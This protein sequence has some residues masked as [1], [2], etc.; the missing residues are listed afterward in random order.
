MRDQAK[1]AAAWAAASDAAYA[2]RAAYAASDAAWDAARDA[3]WDAARAAARDAASKR[4]RRLIGLERRGQL[5]A[6]IARLCE[7]WGVAAE[8]TK[9]EG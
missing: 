2:A 5:D 9:E 6:E 8:R 1:A 3:A 4:L 7:A